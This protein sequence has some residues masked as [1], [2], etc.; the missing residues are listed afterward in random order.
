MVVRVRSTRSTSVAVSMNPR[1]W[2]D[3]EAS[4]LM[5]MLVGDVRCA[6]T[7][8]SD[9]C[10]LSGGSQWSS[11]V[12][13]VSKNCQV[14]RATRR[15]WARSRSSSSTARGRSARLSQKAIAGETIH[16]SNGDAAAGSAAGRT[17]SVSIS[18]PQA[19]A[20]LAH[21]PSANARRPRLRVRPAARAAPA[22][23]VS[24]SSSRRWV[25]KIR[26]SVTAIACSICQECQARNVSSNSD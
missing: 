26:T 20:G 24:H 15:R 9:S 17:A 5:P 10:T 8:P 18:R 12:T 22:A 2:A 3:S 7:R 25:M 6:T 13:N 21:M 11:A 4:R 14:L 16:N 23:A 19:I 1:S